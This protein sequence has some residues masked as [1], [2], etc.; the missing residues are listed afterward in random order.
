MVQISPEGVQKFKKLFNE[1]YDANYSDQEAYEATHNLVWVFDWLLKEDKKQNPEN[2]TK[3][4]NSDDR[5]GV[6]Y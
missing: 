1:K 5:G 6:K 4:N 2:Y 3:K